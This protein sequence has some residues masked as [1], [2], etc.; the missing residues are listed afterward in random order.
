M[1][2]HPTELGHVHLK[3]HV[4]LQGTGDAASGDGPGPRVGLYHVA[5]ECPDPE[6]LTATHERLDDG[7]ASSRRSVTKL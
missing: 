2:G 4:T 6:T 1:T 5:V 7:P 3:V